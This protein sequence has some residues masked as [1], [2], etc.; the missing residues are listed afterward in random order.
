MTLSVCFKLAVLFPVCL[1]LQ[2]IM[3][4]LFLKQVGRL[5][6]VIRKRLERC[7]RSFYCPLLLFNSFELK[8]GSLTENESEQVSSVTHKPGK[9]DNLEVAENAVH[10][11]QRPKVTLFQLYY[12]RAQWSKNPK[13]FRLKFQRKKGA[14]QHN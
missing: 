6:R 1:V 14:D 13:V 2:Y 11:F 9:K 12:L 5:P 10:S 3:Y 7:K 4:F 8:L